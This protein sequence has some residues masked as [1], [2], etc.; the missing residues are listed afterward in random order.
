MKCY[1]NSDLKANHRIGF[2]PAKRNKRYGSSKFRRLLTSA[3]DSDPK[4]VSRNGFNI[5]TQPINK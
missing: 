4:T 3:V 5:P 1:A 2:K